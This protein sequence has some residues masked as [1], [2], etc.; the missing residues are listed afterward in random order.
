VANKIRMSAREHRIFWLAV[1]IARGLGWTLLLVAIL[2]LAQAPFFLAIIGGLKLLPSIAL[3]FVAIAW[4]AT[5]ELFLR[6]FDRYLSR[7]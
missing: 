4:I 5:L 2:G 1:W 7:N 3:I 6:F